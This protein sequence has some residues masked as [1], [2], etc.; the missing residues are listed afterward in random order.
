M[1][2]LLRSQSSVN[3]V[4]NAW[5]VLTRVRQRSAEKVAHFSWTDPV[6]DDVA[7]GC[8]ATRIFFSSFPEINCSFGDV[9]PQLF[10][11]IDIDCQ[12]VAMGIVM[13][14]W[15]PESRKLVC[16]KCTRI[17]RKQRTAREAQPIRRGC[18]IADL[19]R[20]FACWTRRAGQRQDRGMHAL[21]PRSVLQQ[22][23]KQF[24][25]SPSSNCAGE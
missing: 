4:L 17:S 23:L 5:K 25:T 21:R 7:P 1:A 6:A 13:T 14:Q 22:R 19:T 10:V 20:L 11:R 16:A 18:K 12:E 3:I 2:K 8:Y 9:T 15:W 24:I